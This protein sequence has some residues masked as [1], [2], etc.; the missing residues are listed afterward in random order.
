MAVDLLSKETLVQAQGWH[1][2]CA[3]RAAKTA[4]NDDGLPIKRA[5]WRLR[6]HAR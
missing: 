3:D 2:Q 5:G 4:A 1:A 6:V